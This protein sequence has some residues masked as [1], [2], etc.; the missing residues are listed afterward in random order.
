MPPKRR[1]APR[2]KSPSVTQREVEREQLLT[3]QAVAH[4]GNWETDFDRT[5]KVHWSDETYRIFGLA[6]GSFQ[7]THAAFLTYVHPD[8]RAAVDVAFQRSMADRDVHSI[9]HRIVL[10]DG[11]VK[12]VEERWR[13]AAD[14]KGRP[15]RAIGT[16]QDIT[17]RRR[18][19]LEAT[20]L[21]RQVT[22]TLEHLN[23]AFVTI[24]RDWRFTFLN[25]AAEEFIHRPRHELLGLNIWEAFP[26]MIGT[27]FERNYRRAVR[28]GVAVEFEEYYP[29]PLDA[30]FAIR[31]SPIPDGL[32]VTF[33]DITAQRNA[34][35]AIR[36]QAALLD[37]AHEAI[38]VQDLD[39]A[40]IYWNKGAERLYGWT[41]TEAVGRLHTDVCRSDPDRYVEARA[42]LMHSGRWEGEMVER[43]KDGRERTVAVH[44]TLVRGQDGRPKSVCAI[45]T[46][47]SEQKRLQ[48]HL[49]RT[50]R[51]ESLGTLAGGIAHDLNNVLTPIL[52]S[53]ELLREGEREGERLETLD[54]IRE[55]ARRGAALVRQ[56]LGF[57]RGVE[58][59]RI[60]VDPAAVVADLEAFLG[61]TLPKGIRLS[62]T[63]A[64]SVPS[65]IGDATQLHQVLMNLAVNARDAMPGGGR[66]TIAL[67]GVVLGDAEIRPHPGVAAGSF[68]LLEVIDTGTGI[69]PEIIERVFEPFFTTK[70]FGEGTGLGLST[71]HSIVRDHGGFIT[72]D[73]KVDQGS[74]FRVYLPTAGAV[75]TD[76]DASADAPIQRGQ[77]ELILVVDDEPGIRS[78]VKRTL[79]RFGYRV[80]VAANGFEA[81]TLYAEARGTV[82]AVLTDMAM[83]VMDGPTM[84]LKLKAL[85]PKARIIGSSGLTSND[86]LTSV[87]GAGVRHF[88]PKPYTTEALLAT[89][90]AAL[91]ADP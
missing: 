49:F 91:T 46:D 15:T 29:A 73:S 61:D 10:A 77:G 18:V 82:G 37:A 25:R 5:L 27:P 71:V 6:P 44:W 9:E 22:E 34:Q 74:H 76:A 66:L 35:A 53:I 42:L 14:T 41:S 48:V 12:V 80:L 90:S 16:C 60:A 78:I 19:E 52:A 70:P 64:R 8:D 47:I 79:E 17:D 4:I 85:D 24:D 62:V 32:A 3:A 1:P 50:Q 81:L 28:E 58:G 21:A 68:V 13:T 72:L 11:T 65:V 87:V 45:N 51:L 59:D 39:G 83:P 88:V 86:A 2:K 43:G 31:A 75:R 26:A 30:W 56:V 67:S 20:A 89:L 69:P 84:I 40:I 55:S 54:T 57:A 23:D 36:D 33:Q 38:F 63:I 7:P